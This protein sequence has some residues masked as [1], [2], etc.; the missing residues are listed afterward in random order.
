MV[1]YYN[2]LLYTY[3]KIYE[4]FF[5]LLILK[6]IKKPTNK[7]IKKRKCTKNDFW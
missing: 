4:K 1:Y 6:K 7:N 5:K 2:F 3:V